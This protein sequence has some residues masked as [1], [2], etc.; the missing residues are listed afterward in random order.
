VL[1]RRGAVRAVD[2]VALHW[3][4]VPPRAGV[5][6]AGLGDLLDDAGAR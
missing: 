1:D 4:V 6:S 2:A 3:D 5:G